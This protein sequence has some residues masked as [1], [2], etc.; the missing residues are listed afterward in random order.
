[1]FYVMPCEDKKIIDDLSKSIFNYPNN[2]EGNLL[3]FEDKKPIGLCNFQILEAFHI[4]RIGVLDC[5]EKSA[6]DFFCRV[7]IFKALNNKMLVVDFVDDYYKQ[8]GF[9]IKNNTM[10]ALSEEIN[11][12]SECKH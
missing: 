8:F 12:P 3:L 9:K 5:Y 4:C 11:F 7:V 10:V 2:F 1:M 6:K